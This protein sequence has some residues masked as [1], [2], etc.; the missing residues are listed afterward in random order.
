MGSDSAA[1]FCL[2]DTSAIFTVR[3][4]RGK[5]LSKSSMFFSN[6]LPL[7][8]FCFLAEPT[9]SPTLHSQISN[10]QLHQSNSS[11]CSSKSKFTFHISTH[12]W[13]N[14]SLFISFSAVSFS[15]ITDSSTIALP[16]LRP[17]RFMVSYFER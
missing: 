15:L 2:S 8:S 13:T 1:P 10:E 14:R 4:S 6:V 3:T 9:Q 12:R 17:F 7:S 16:V 11:V 5:Y